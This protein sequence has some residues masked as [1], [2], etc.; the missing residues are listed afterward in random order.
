VGFGREAVMMEVVNRGVS[1]IARY[2][3]YLITRPPLITSGL[4]VPMTD[5]TEG[6]KR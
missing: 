3:M 4:Y 5:V 2:Y 6:I 1:K